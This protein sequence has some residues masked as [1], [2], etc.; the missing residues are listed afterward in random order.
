MGGGDRGEPVGEVVAGGPADEGVAEVAVGEGVLGDGGAGLE[1]RGRLGE[2]RRQTGEVVERE[3]GGGIR[4]HGQAGRVVE[5]LPDGGGALAVR[6]VL[7]PDVG[8]RLV[9]HEPPVGDHVEDGQGCEG[10]RDRVG[11]D[12]GV[13]RPR[14]AAVPR[15][16]DVVDDHLA[17]ADHADGA[18]RLAAGGR[19][20]VEQRGGRV[21]H[22]R[23]AETT[24]RASACTWARWSGPRNDSA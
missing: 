12:E 1:R 5:D 15:A 19:R 20:V 6:G 18:A 7:G 21:G 11:H 13:G 24:S 8:H 23:A 2:Q 4:E 10:L 3:V 9:Q 17:V 14:H 16:D 22:P